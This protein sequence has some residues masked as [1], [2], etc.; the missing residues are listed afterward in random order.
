MLSGPLLPLPSQHPV[1]VLLPRSS[2]AVLES[3]GS[4]AQILITIPL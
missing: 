4:K 1:V 2:G 3:S